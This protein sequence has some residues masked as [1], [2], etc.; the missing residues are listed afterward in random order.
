[1]FCGV[2]KKIPYLLLLTGLGVQ[3]AFSA[4]QLADSNSSS[5][6][7]ANY[8][9]NFLHGHPIVQ[10]GYYWDTA[11]KT[12]HINIQNLVGNTY[13]ANGGQRNNGLVGIGY[14]IDGPDIRQM[15]M[16]YGLNWFYLPKTTVSGTVIQEDLFANLAYHYNIT[17]YPL[18]IIAKSTI[19][20][21][22]PLYA[23]TV[24]IGIGP[25]FIQTSDFK[26]S[27]INN[28]SVPDVLFAGQTTITFS[29]TASVG[30]KFNRVFSQ[31][32][33]ECGYRFF[34]L[35]QGNFAK[36]NNQLNTFTTG[37]MNANAV[38]CSIKF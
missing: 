20:T 9:F 15:Q 32:P 28:N 26:E 14:L 33:L 31:A 2:C 11:G 23:F 17:Q 22:S 27:S 1:M 5:Q 29:A 18:Y 36:N 21:P 10:L 19:P 16:S 24:D 7:S 8:S 4:T 30:I 13:T 25:N 37:S 12:Q 6:S 35:G 3:V 38:I 34:Y